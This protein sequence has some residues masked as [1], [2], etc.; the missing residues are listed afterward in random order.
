MDVT[1]SND[2]LWY[3][4]HSYGSYGRDLGYCGILWKIPDIL[5]DIT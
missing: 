1:H 2:N 5:H 4:Y 3:F